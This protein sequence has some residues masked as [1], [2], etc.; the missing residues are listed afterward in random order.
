MRTQETR[1]RR[2][3]RAAR[4]RLSRIETQREQFATGYALARTSQE[5]F[6]A[7]MFALRAAV[8]DK[9]QVDPTEV[10]RR[11]NVLT[12]QAKALLDELHTAQQHQANQTIRADARRIARNE[13]RRHERRSRPESGR[14]GSFPA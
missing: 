13:R 4:A 2:R 3:V 7:V 12:D 5:R 8:A 11:L 6:N 10:A 1:E 14:V 9:H